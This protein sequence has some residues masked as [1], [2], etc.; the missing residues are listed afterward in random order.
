[1]S[2]K[3]AEWLVACDESGS[4]QTPYSG[5][6]SLWMRWE[7]RGDFANLFEELRDKYDFRTEAKWKRV[8]KRSYSFAAALVEEFFKRQWLSFHCLVIRKAVIDKSLHDGDYELAWQK[9]FTMLLTNKMKQC[10]KRH[11]D[12]ENVFR[13]WV[14]PIQSSYPKTDE[15]VEIIANHVLA[16]AV[17]GR[18]AIDKV[19]TRDSKET[20]A[21]QLCDILLGAVLDAWRRNA[22][23]D[24]KLGVQR[25]IAEHLGWPDLQADTD[26]KERKFNIWY[27]YDPVRQKSREVQMRLVNLRYPL[28]G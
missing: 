26:P 23:S 19:I 21:I 2:L 8:N 7:R 12:R 4:K 16:R 15:V 28:P 20:P 22:E 5:F 24:E 3:R 25:L 14:D 17:P 11:R 27:F 9:H 10:L 6:G 1:M 13:V 18:R